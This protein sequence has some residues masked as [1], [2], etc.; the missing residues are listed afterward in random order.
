MKQTPQSRIKSRRGHLGVGQWLAIAFLAVALALLW[1]GP[2]FAATPSL[3][4]HVTDASTGLPITTAQVNVSFMDPSNNN[5]PFGGPTDTSG[6]WTY[7][8]V[9]PG[10]YK[11]QVSDSSHTYIA[12]WYG[13]VPVE[14]NVP[15][16]TDPNGTTAGTVTVVAGDNT[17]NIALTRGY[18]IRG[19]V[20]DLSTGLGIRGVPVGIFDASGNDLMSVDDSTDANGNYQSFALIPGSYKV[21]TENMGDNGQISHNYIDQWYKG[22]VC[23]SDPQGDTATLIDASKP[24]A[25]NVNFAL[26]LG[27]VISGTVTDASTHSPF[28]G[29]HVGADDGYG[30]QFGLGF[31][32]ENGFYTS[33]GLLPGDYKISTGWSYPLNYVNQWYKSTGSVPVQSDPD[34][35][36]V[37]PVSLT[38]AGV[39]AD[40]ALEM[41]GTI[42]GTVTYAPNGQSQ[43]RADVQLDAYDANGTW[44]GSLGGPT[45]PDGK[46]SSLGGLI[47]GTYKVVASDNNWPDHY[48]APAQTVTVTKDSV[49]PLDFAMTPTVFYTISGRVTDAPTG[50]PIP[51]VSVEA[52]SPGLRGEP[53]QAVT[54]ENGYY[55]LKYLL[56]GP[57]FVCTDTPDYVNQWY[58]DDPVQGDP[59]AKAATSVT[60]TAADFPGVQNVNFALSPNTPAG[61]GTVVTFPMGMGS[62]TTVTF[63][64]VTQTGITSMAPVDSP[65]AQFAVNGGCYDVTTTCAY[66]GPIV[67]SFPYD[68]TALPDPSLVRVLHWQGGAWVDVTEKVENGLVY[69]KVNSL[70]PFVIVTNS[71]PAIVLPQPGPLPEGSRLTA[72]GSFADPDSTAWTATVDYGDNSGVQPLALNADKTF[73]LSHTY[74]DEGTYP[75]TVN[76]TDNGGA[77]GTATAMMTLNNVPPTVGKVTIPAESQALNALVTASAPFTDPGTLDT[78]TATWD[79]GDGSTSAGTVTES[80]GSGSVTGSHAYGKPGPYTV[81]LTVTDADG[82]SST[83]SA[84]SVKVLGVALYSGADASLSGSCKVESP[85]V[86]GQPSAASYING[87]LATSGSANLSQTVLYVKAKGATVPPL[88]QFMPSSLV[89]SLITASR[90]AQQTGTVYK[91]LVLSGS[92]GKSFNGPVTVNGDLT[93]SGSGTYTFNSVYVTGNVTISGSPTFSFASLYVGGKLTVSGGV[94]SQWGPT[95][96]AG[97]TSLSGSGQWA[98]SLFVTAGSFTLSGSETIG[99]DGQGGHAT[100]VRVF[101]VG[102]G[103]QATISGSGLFYGLLYNQSGGLTISGSSVVRGSVLLGG[104]YTA[105]GSTDLKYDAGVLSQLK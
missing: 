57:G 49:T 50:N 42:S 10:T 29:L 71:P 28:A 59:E 41:G 30:D 37:T 43:P 105:T 54:D 60:I 3:K 33:G 84:Q 93:I 73:N 80:Q 99:G 85:I 62:S 90:A 86:G 82:A 27:C 95:Y 23:Q 63:S 20:K 55:T 34:G 18:S 21:A 79:W 104:S 52:I 15:V 91:G 12:E 51:N 94:A 102:Q 78:H 16:Q 67:V 24:E 44:V 25:Q 8:G 58:K 14:A 76:V 17:I 69:A 40:F 26:T 19:V 96:V 56:P 11:V 81:S 101:L 75:V 6:T 64:T 32:D 61:N 83:G 2:V 7:D 47:P 36:N 68:T 65:P 31:T 87:K 92:Q 66:T 4:V 98:A 45:G 46:Y 38:L 35:T 77:T 72:Q 22:D 100:P 48:E 5:P 1:T 9:P 74:A 39:T 88:S 53:S 97:D 103:K 89:S 13:N 70:S